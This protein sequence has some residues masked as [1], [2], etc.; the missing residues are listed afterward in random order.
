MGIIS[1]CQRKIGGFLLLFFYRGVGSPWFYLG[2]YVLINFG[3]AGAMLS[4][5]LYG[6]MIALRA[7]RVAYLSS[8]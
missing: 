8:Y 4:R 5:E 7:S 6:R 2:I 1:G 3:L